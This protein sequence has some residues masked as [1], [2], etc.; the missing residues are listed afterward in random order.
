MQVLPLAQAELDGGSGF[1]D[2]MFGEPDGLVQATPSAT[3]R[4]SYIARILSGGFPLALTRAPGPSRSR[5]F[6]DYVR[7]T[8]AKD[9]AELSK[10]RQAQALP[11]LLGHL[12]GQTAQ[13]VNLSRIAAKMGAEP[14][15]VSGHMRLLE[16]VFLIRSLPG[17]GT[18][19]ASRMAVK[20][21]IHV[22]DSGVCGWLSRIT[23][24]RLARREPSAL[25][26]L[27]YLAETFAVGEILKE[28]GWSGDAGYETGHWR[29]WDDDEV[30]LVVER[31]DG[32]VAAFEIKATSGPAGGSFA[33]LEKLRNR[34]G[35]SFAG[36][37]VLH[38]GERS[39]RHSPNLVSLPLDTCWRGR[40]SS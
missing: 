28:A 8:L 20:P 29:T 31:Q 11:A 27:G 12:A 22:V 7:A 6:A 5:W 17:W 18:T 38:F 37:A 26:E 19:L 34:L 32:M 14:S 21:K 15:T 33:G 24:R 13:V 35:S 9:V 36:G 3:S 2:A 30:D 4:D 25:T 10:V 39:F 16:A 1:L 40:G 23:S